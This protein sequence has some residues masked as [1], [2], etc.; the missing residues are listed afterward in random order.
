MSRWDEAEDEGEDQNWG[1]LMIYWFLW[2]GVY[3]DALW[4]SM[5]DYEKVIFRMTSSYWYF[6]TWR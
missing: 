6:I 2:L 4:L 1:I 5:R 3:I